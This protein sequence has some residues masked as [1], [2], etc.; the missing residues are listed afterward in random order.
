MMGI[1]MDDEGL[2]GKAFLTDCF[3]NNNDK[4]EESRMINDQRNGVKMVLLVG[5]GIWQWKMC[6][7]EAISL[8]ESGETVSGAAEL[9]RL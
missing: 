1:V 5:S 4:G 2:P 3:N 6:C 8:R 9:R 7:C